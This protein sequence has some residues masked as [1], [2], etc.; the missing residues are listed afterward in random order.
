MRKRETTQRRDTL[1]HNAQKQ[2]THSHKTQH[3]THKHRIERTGHSHTTHMT[4]HTCSLSRARTHTVFTETRTIY[5]YSASQCSVCKRHARRQY[6]NITTQYNQTLTL[7]TYCAPSCVTNKFRSARSLC[8]KLFSSK[9]RI[10]AAASF[11]L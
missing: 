2:R 3:N 5:Q 4:Q 11:A 10:P 6:S 8:K 9:C 1:T 7:T